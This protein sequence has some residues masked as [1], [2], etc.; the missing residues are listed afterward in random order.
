MTEGVRRKLEITNQTTVYMGYQD[1]L[2]K[3]SVDFEAMGLMDPIEAQQLIPRR[4]FWLPL[5]VPPYYYRRRRMQSPSSG[6]EQR[7]ARPRLHLDH[8]CRHQLSPDL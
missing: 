5:S 2:A 3:R 6:E 8:T 4:H 1:K 7:K